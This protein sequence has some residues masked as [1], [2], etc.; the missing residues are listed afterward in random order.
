[1]N[2]D[3]TKKEKY[4]LKKQKREKEHL[5][6]T[7]NRK[8]KKLI[9]I[10]LPTL[11]VAGGIAF[12]LINYSPGEKLE[13][14]PRI[15]ISPPEYDLGIISMVEGKIQR[16]FEVKNTGEGDLEITGI[17]TS[18]H[19][20]TARLKVGDRESPE[21]GMSSNPIFWSQ[22]I[23]PGQTGY[24]EVTFDPAYHGSQGTG[25]VIRAIYLSTND[26]QNKTAEVRLIANVVE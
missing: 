13:G 5:R 19:C 22:K 21:F 14:T 2:N 10:S 8:L 9:A 7:R 6:Q 18:C 1:M 17:W 4:L 20:T 16:T 12:G 24:L 11:L 15:E 3:L 25:P 26:S 23:A